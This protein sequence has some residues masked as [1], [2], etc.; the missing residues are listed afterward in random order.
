MR[1]KT[2]ARALGVVV[3]GFGDRRLVVGSPKSLEPMTVSLPLRDI[4]QIAVLGTDPADPQRR[5]TVAA[6][7]A[8]DKWVRLGVFEQASDADALIR[9]CADS[10]AGS[11]WKQV[12]IT[13]GLSMVVGFFFLVLANI[14]QMTATG[15]RDAVLAVPPPETAQLPAPVALPQQ[16][17]LTTPAVDPAVPGVPAAAAAAAPVAPPA[18]APVSIAPAPA[19]AAQVPLQVPAPQEQALK[20]YFGAQPAKK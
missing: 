13:L 15:K 10:M 12:W 9:A 5:F 3:R 17:V 7:I 19:A 8:P 16:P 11:R 6:Q 4:R 2:S 1:M 14:F 18:P 20:D